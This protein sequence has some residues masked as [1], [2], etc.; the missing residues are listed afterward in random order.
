METTGPAAISVS[1]PEIGQPTARGVLY[2]NVRLIICCSWGGPVHI[3]VS[4][5]EMK[6]STVFSHYKSRKGES[7][8]EWRAKMR[9]ILIFYLCYNFVGET[10]HI[11][12]SYGPA[13]THH[14]WES[15]IC[16]IRIWFFL[17]QTGHSPCPPGPPVHVVW[18][19][20]E[21]SRPWGTTPSTVLAFL[22]PHIDHWSISPPATCLLKPSHRGNPFSS[23]DSHSWLISACFGLGHLKVK[24]QCPL[25]QG[26][27]AEEH[28]SSVSCAKSY[29]NRNSSG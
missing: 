11:S 6:S 16:P 13:A 15:C 18:V 4:G 8:Q 29:G 22:L 23:S 9:K 25:A 17:L 2:K 26:L 1:T 27:T 7:M 20:L 14:Y 19:W 24:M 10:V 28:E 3:H 12:K 5:P 21:D